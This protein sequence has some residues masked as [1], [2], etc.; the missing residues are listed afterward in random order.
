[1]MK[2]LKSKAIEVVDSE[3]EPKVVAELITLQEEISSRPTEVVELH[4]KTHVDLLAEP[5]L[6][7][8]PSL[9]VMMALIF[10][11]LPDAR[12][13]ADLSPGASFTGDWYLVM[14]VRCQWSGVDLSCCV[15]L[16]R[17]PD[18]GYMFVMEADSTTTVVSM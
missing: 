15:Y 5:T 16:T 12:S 6:E 13:L 18:D 1:M 10:F 9:A 17:T 8:V 3:P 14:W 7:V 2:I 4:I 11:R